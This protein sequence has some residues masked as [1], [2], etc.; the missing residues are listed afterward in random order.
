MKRIALKRKESVVRWDFLSS[1]KPP[2]HLSLETG[3]IFEA[4]QIY[5]GSPDYDFVAQQFIS[6]FKGR[7]PGA[8]GGFNNNNMM[9]AGGGA[10]GMG[11]YYGGGMALNN[12]FQV[13]NFLAVGA[14]NGVVG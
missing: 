2:S 8:G 6:T 4:K 11:Y 9:M 13:G 3:N 5:P 7:N 14:I 12:P 10:A 1:F